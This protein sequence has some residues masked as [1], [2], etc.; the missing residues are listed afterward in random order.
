MIK[1][2]I[3]FLLIILGISILF[4]SSIQINYF[5]N[6]LTAENLTFTGNQNITRNFSIST[7]VNITKATMN[8]S[9]YVSWKNMS[10]GFSVASLTSGDLPPSG[11]TTNG[12]DFWL[13]SYGLNSPTMIYHLNS[14][15]SNLS[16]S[17]QFTSSFSNHTTSIFYNGSGLWVTSFA[18][19]ASFYNLSGSFILTKNLRIPT[20]IASPHGFYTNNSDYY[21]TSG[22]GSQYFIYH[23]NSSFSNQSDGF[24]TTPL[25]STCPYSLASL[26]NGTDFYFL[27]YAIPLVYNINRSGSLLGD[28]FS[29][30]ILSS[31]NT[32][33][34]S[35][36]TNGS[37]FWI[38]NGNERFVYHVSKT[39]SI[40]NPFLSINNYQIWNYTGEFNQT[41]NKTSDFSVVLNSAL[42]NKKCDCVGCSLSGNNCSIPFTFHSDV[43]GI[44]KYSDI[45]IEYDSIPFVY[46]KTPTN[47]SYSSYTN[48]FTCNSS[49]ELQLSNVT[50][51]IW[52]STGLYNNTEFREIS[53]NYNSTTFNE[54]TF[55]NT[56]N[57]T[58]NCLVYNN[59]SYSNWNSN[60]TLN[61]DT[62]NPVTQL[63]FP[64]NNKYLNYKDNINFNCSTAGDDLDSTFLYGNFNGTYY[65]N[66][67]KLSIISG[68]TNTFMLNLSDGSYLWTCGA[69]KTVSSTIIISQYGNYT[70]NID[71]IKPNVNITSLIG[72]EGSQTIYF[73]TSSSDLNLDRCFYTIFDINGTVNGLNNNVSFTCNSNP[74]S[75]TVTAY[76]TYNLTVDVYDK[77]NN[78]N[79]Y[80]NTFTVNP[81]GVVVIGGGGTVIIGSLL[82]ENFSVVS[83][84]YGNVMDL[85]LAKGSVREREKEFILVN[86]G[87]DSFRI[88]LSCNTNDVNQNISEGAK[89][90]IDICQYVRFEQD[91]L[92]ISPNEDSPTISKVYVMVPTDAEFGDKYAFNVIATRSE[93]GI[94]TYSKL[95]ISARVTYWALLFKYSYIPFQAEDKV[96]KSMYPVSL[97]AGLLS[98]GLFSLVLYLLRRFILVGFFVGLLL[99]IIAFISM[100]VFF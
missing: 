71:T 97:I 29:T 25:N 21:F 40:F 63:L 94:T 62:G 79:Y 39:F 30:I 33:W 18:V 38:L 61:V 95:S 99:S 31:K 34:V 32:S 41:N 100:L 89:T 17:F 96:D 12:S 55:S 16:D 59:K 9:T 67:T 11:I 85:V 36:T 91:E 54:I 69:N 56:D 35:I 47:N 2:K 83:S 66:K 19:F 13:S 48:K 80:T 20:L 28:S 74:Q 26:N 1:K 68:E 23:L 93:S 84:G 81:S 86:K 10:D 88:K 22:C 8:L 44:L 5:S 73:N 27:D 43:S 37:D 14:S 58:W 64:T 53:G 72:T 50:L 92:D 70:V 77:A 75:A 3:L 76:G 78:H 42:N 15:G 51:Y 49:D 52:N 7:N 4:V 87:I 98:I 82:A 90:D 45:N 46:L 24:S 6:G 60:Y 65:L 57:Y